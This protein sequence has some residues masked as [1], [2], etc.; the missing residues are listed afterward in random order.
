MTVYKTTKVLRDRTDKNFLYKEGQVFPRE[1]HKVP[2]KRL[3]ELVK[4]GHLVKVEETTK[5]ASKQAKKGE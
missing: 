3:N 2:E 5:E 1:G 4:E